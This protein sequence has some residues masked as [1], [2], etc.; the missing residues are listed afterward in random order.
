MSKPTKNRHLKRYV[1]LN[2]VGVTFF[3]NYDLIRGGFPNL[4]GQD[5]FRG[6]PEL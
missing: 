2:Q 6:N 4:K 5:V 3:V 1:N